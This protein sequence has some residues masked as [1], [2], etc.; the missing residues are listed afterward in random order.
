MGMSIPSLRAR[1]VT[2]LAFASPS[3]TTWRPSK[4]ASHGVPRPNCRP[5]DMLR[6]VG[7]LHV[8]DRSPM[9]DNPVSVSLRPDQCAPVM[10]FASADNDRQDLPS[11]TCAALQQKKQSFRQAAKIIK[12]QKVRLRLKTAVRHSLGDACFSGKRPAGRSGCTDQFSNSAPAS[13][14]TAF[15][16]NREHLPPD[17][18][19]FGT[20]PRSTGI[21]FDS[22]E[23]F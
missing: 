21:L 20:A 8:N 22:L 7:L 19:A 18:G 9:P 11:M 13:A 10:C 5:S 3:T 15:I 2:D 17:S 14:S 6:D 4:Q 23:V 12:R 16:A 1:S